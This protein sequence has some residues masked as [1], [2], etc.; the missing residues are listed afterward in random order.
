MRMTRFGRTSRITMMRRGNN[1]V[2]QIGG[3]GV[4]IPFHTTWQHEQTEEFEHPKLFRL[5]RFEDLCG[6][7]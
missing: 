5:A 1:P 2:L 3:Y 7:L 6:I 4:Y